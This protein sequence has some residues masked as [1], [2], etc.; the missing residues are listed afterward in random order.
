MQINPILGIK[1]IISVFWTS[2]SKRPTLRSKWLAL[3][4]RIIEI[5]ASNIG[6]ETEYYNWESSWFTQYLQE[7]GGIH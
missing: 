2:T 6:S 7:I 3:I 1:Y 5:L 4:L